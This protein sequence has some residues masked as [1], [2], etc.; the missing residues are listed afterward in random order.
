MLMFCW[1]GGLNRRWCCCRYW[2]LVA[3]LQRNIMT[4]I[5]IACRI[6]PNSP[7]K[8]ITRKLAE[9]LLGLV[10]LQ[11]YTFGVGLSRPYRL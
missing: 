5:G 2:D 1:C 7:E 4:W 11:V 9:V 8:E 10:V 3:L 6:D